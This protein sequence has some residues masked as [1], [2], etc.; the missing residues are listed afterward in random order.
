MTSI[1]ARLF[2]ILMI[3]TG[4]VWMSAIV[5]IYLSTRAEVERVLDARLIEAARMVSSLITSQE[6]D[7]RRAAQMPALGTTTHASYERQLSCQIWALDGT[8]VG[9]S[10]AAPAAPLTDSR[11]GFSETVVGG[12]TWRVYAVINRDLG[13]RVLV[14]DNMRVRDQLVADVIRGLA[15]PA[16][17]VLPIL[18]GLLWLSVRKGLAPLNAMARALATRPASD[19]SALPDADAPSEIKPVIRS[20]NGLFDRVSAVRAHERDFTAFAAH[21]LRTPIAG[22]K[23][24]AQVALGSDDKA[25]RE[26]ALR[27]IVLGV[28]RTARLVRQ[29]TDLTNAESG[30]LRH[31]EGGVSIGGALQILADDIEQH[32]PRTSRVLIC[33]ELEPV[34]LSV[35]PSLFM[36]SARNLLENAV[37]HSPRDLPVR[38]SLQ[39]DKRSI[40][41]MIDDCGPGIPEDEL[42]RVRDRFF[43]GRNKA[44]M[45]SGLGLAIADLALERIGAELNLENRIEG[46]LRA[47]LRFD[48]SLL[49]GSGRI[50]NMQQHP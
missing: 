3:T 11:D 20:L 25:I 34:R 50:F 43:R 35:N 31:E 30:E 17:L 24:Q 38:C 26:N 46:G 29:L 10:D 21:E 37:L 47:E 19:L 32:Y 41:I 33:A 9:R 48:E 27:Q 22:L 13:M 14:G 44:L 23:T 42:P 7:P 15:L 36:M 8:L 5:W 28:D 45:G 1:R 16:L 6:I 39:K 12:E 2:F 40:V 18:A 4:V 49:A